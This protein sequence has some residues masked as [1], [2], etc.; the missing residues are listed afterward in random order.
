M[1]ACIFDVFAG[2]AGQMGKSI[3]IAA[4]LMLVAGYNAIA[5][6]QAPVARARAQLRPS[7]TIGQGC[8]GRTARAIWPRHFLDRSQRSFVYL[9]L[10]T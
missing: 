1:A 10:G 5:D 6:D 2:D 7:I 8:G 3:I 4:V 9:N